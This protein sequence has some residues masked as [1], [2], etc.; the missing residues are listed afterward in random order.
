MRIVVDVMGTPMASGGM[1]LYARELLTAWAEEVPEDTLILV[2]GE[3]V[4]ALAAAHPGRIVARVV[5]GESIL[6]RFWTQLVRSGLIARR[7]HADALL[8]LSPIAA[9]TF[10]ADREAAVVHD[11][12]HL[13]RP[14]EFGRFQ[15]L[16]R[17]LWIPSLRRVRTAIAISEKTDA[18]TKEF[19]VGAN[20]LVVRNGG[21]HPRHWPR[22]EPAPGGPARVLTYGHFVNK[23]PEAVIEAIA[24]LRDGGTPAR[25]TVLGAKGA[26][27][28]GLAEL[29]AARGVSEL[30]RFPGFVEDA[31]YQELLQRSDVVVLNSS[32][33]GFGLPVVEARYF[34]IPVVAA[35]DSGLSEIHGDSIVVSDPSAAP[36]AEAIGAAAAAGRARP[37]TLRT[38]GDTARE[39]RASLQSKTSAVRSSRGTEER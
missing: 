10:D 20:S 38:W 37:A 27:Q 8:S 3:W 26:Y 30:V 36:L 22:V 7:E 21:D 13:R 24:L 2:G 34:G 25:L 6:S 11:W 31:E 9:F 5:R 19:A 14:E 28:E 17:R 32:D 18:E 15:R 35:A 29:A 16:Y 23:R 39:I 1:N 12:R 33:E 4:T